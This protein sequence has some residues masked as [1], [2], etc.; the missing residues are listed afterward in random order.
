M[1]EDV[2]FKK[3]VPFNFSRQQLRFRVSQDLFSSQDIDVGTR[4]LLRSVITRAANHAFR[5]VLDLGCGYG[6]L[7]LTLK[8][9]DK[10]RLVDLTDRDALA[11]AYSRQ[12]AALNDLTQGTDS[13]GSL[14]YDDLRRSDF[15]LIVSNI[16]GK[17]GDPVIASLLRDAKCALAP[18][19]LAAVV[20]VSPLAQTVATML[21]APDIEVVWREAR[22]GHTV[23]HYRFSDTD[24]ATLPCRESALARGVYERTIET[25]SAGGIIYSMQ[26]AYGMPEFDTPSYT[27]QV[28]I[29][30]L[31]GLRRRDVPRAVV[32]NPGQGHAAVALWKLM[33]P[34]ALALVGRDLL[35]LRTSGRNLERN[36][37]PRGQITLSHQVGIGAAGQAEADLVVGML[38]EDEGPA[39]AELTIMQG[40]RQLAPG[41]I[42]VVAGSSTAI[43][44][45]ATF[46]A[47]EPALKAVDRHRQ[48]GQSALI[49][50]KRVDGP[51]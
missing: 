40:A 3:V 12:N 21:G 14:G 47:T 16:P 23:F 50:S 27:T 39:A 29:E 32:F 18:D 36:G 24:H 35:A 34:R 33:A 9:M 45:L 5:R 46:L 2:Y 15:D 8:A 31:R 13:Y 41:G 43:T 51:R 48:R 6:P 37:C 7:G 1:D 42:M 20:V 28:L 10:D 17:A 30:S 38:R 19:G 22:A 25:I 11:V 49:L 4:F 44:R 26:T